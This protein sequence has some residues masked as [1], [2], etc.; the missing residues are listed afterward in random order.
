MQCMRAAAGAS[1]SP[2]GGIMSDPRGRA[3]Q[4][5]LADYLS[6]N[7][8]PNAE[9][10]GS[11]LAGTDIKGTPGLV[12]ENKTA[13]GFKRDFRPLEWVRQSKGH[14]N[15]DA[16]LIPITVYFPNGVGARRV[17][18]TIAMLPTHLLIRLLHEAGYGT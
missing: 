7:G 11:G 9:S 6:A 15:G 5:A 13:R 17:G 3:L 16:A 18:D 8:W 2:A 12:W 14:A 10:V 1:R 4:H